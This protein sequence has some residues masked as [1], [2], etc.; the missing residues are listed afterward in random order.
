MSISTED[1]KKAKTLLESGKDLYPPCDHEHRHLK[2]YE[3]GLCLL[4]CPSCNFWCY[5]AL[6]TL[7]EITLLDNS[8]L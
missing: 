8:P 6:K 2:V 3:G 5:I 7:L 4:M 1:F